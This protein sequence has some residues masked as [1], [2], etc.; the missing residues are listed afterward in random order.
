M[1]E[2]TTKDYYAVIMAGGIGSRFWPVSTSSFPK[3]FHDMLGTGKSLLQQ[4][5]SRLN[6]LIPSENILILTNERYLELTLSQLPEISE[7]QVVLEPAMRNTAPC[8]LLSALKIK[9]ENPNAVMLVAPSDH[10]IEDEDAFA[11]DVQKC[12]DAAQ[13]DNILM[14]LGINPTFPNTGY[15]Y[16]EADK[17]STSE[18]SRVAQFREKPDYET[19]KKFLNEGNFLWNAGIFIWSVATISEA[20]EKNEPVMHALFSEGIPVYNT[21]EEKDFIAT[22]YE[23]SENISIDYAIMEKAN[24]VFTKKATFDWNDLGTWGALHDKMTT[25]EGD[26]AV[27]RGIP[28]LTDAKGNMIYSETE[29]LIVVDGIDDYI[30]V[31]KAET[32]LI[33]PKKKEQDIKKLLVEVENTHG[34]KYT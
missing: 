26:N 12:F 33:F 32:L 22:N 3:Q 4:T 10:W 11:N 28:M 21:T 16:I 8:I 20:F 17:N 24:N 5:F 1:K 15:G 19:A 6:K 14:T 2:S 25:N 23:L 18:I 13:H 29:K 30:I 9:K 34:K 7:K 27:V 31:D